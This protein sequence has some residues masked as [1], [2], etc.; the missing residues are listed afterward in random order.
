MKIIKKKSK[1]SIKYRYPKEDNE[2]NE[3]KLLFKSKKNSRRNKTKPNKLKKT[4]DKIKKIRKKENG[5]I[6]LIMK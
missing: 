5:R 4:K 1:S 6:I 3:T 2:S